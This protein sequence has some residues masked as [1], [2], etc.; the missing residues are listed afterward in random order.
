MSTKDLIL[1]LVTAAF[2]GLQ[3]DPT[4]AIA[5]SPAAEGAIRRSA[6]DAALQW[7]GCPDFLPAGCA[8]AVLH[9]DPSQPNVDVFFRVPGGSEIPLHTH[10]SAER[11]IL[12][13]GELEVTYQDQAPIRLTPGDY[14]YGP[15]GLPHRGRCLS[16]A[17]CT[18]FIAFELPLD[19]V[20]AAPAG[21]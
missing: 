12:V 21:D 15:A 9:G 6:G 7:G 5:Q 13:A 17:A 18:L 10:T 19:A 2:L 4:P 1:A 14:A 16:D 3:A 20:P 8:I 11:M